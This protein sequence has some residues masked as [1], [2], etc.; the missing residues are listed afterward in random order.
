[1]PRPDLHGYHPDV[2]VYEVRETV[3]SEDKLVALFLH[4]NFARQHKQS[5]NHEPTLELFQY[6]YHLYP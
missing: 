1:M 3:A 6:L 4:D 2:L 5:G